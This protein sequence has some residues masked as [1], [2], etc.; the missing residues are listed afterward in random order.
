MMPG[1]ASGSETVKKVRTGPAPML[2]AASSSE[3]STAAN[4]AAAIHTDSTSPCSEWTSTT[5]TIVPLRP[6]Q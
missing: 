1:A 6:I 5:P 2:R 3:R 4:A